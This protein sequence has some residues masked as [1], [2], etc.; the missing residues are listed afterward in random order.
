MAK[1]KAE[2]LKDAQG[3]G[4][5]V[6]TKNTVAE[7]TAAIAAMSQ[8]PVEPIEEGNLK[9][10]EEGEAIQASEAKEQVSS[11]ADVTPEI[12]DAIVNAEAAEVVAEK[13]ATSTVHTAK[14]GKRSAKSVA[15]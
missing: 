7:I 15:E 5:E 2:L 10:A 11:T 8:T 1:S 9:V 6:T 14:A 4:L 13:E 3:M 12:E